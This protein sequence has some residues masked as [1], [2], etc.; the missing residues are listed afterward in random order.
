[1]SVQHDLALI[2]ET[3]ASNP[4]GALEH[5]ATMAVHEL[6]S[7]VSARAR[8]FG[9]THHLLVK[10]TPPVIATPEA[11]VSEFEERFP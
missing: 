1:M 3:G 6:S 9:K 5:V 10:F 8:Q 4:P 2:A 7:L 11:G